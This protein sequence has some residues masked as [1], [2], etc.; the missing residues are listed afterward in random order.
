MSLAHA[1]PRT[2]DAPKMRC[3]SGEVA[4]HSSGCD[5]SRKSYFAGEDELSG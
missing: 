3:E 5:S 2:K 1:K 4:E